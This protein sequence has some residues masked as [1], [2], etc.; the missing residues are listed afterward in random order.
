[1]DWVQL[2]GVLGGGAASGVLL[3]QLQ[4]FCRYAMKHRTLTRVIDRADSTPEQWQAAADALATID[5]PLPVPRPAHRASLLAPP[6]RPSPPSAP[7]EPAGISVGPAPGPDLPC[8]ACLVGDP[9]PL[10]S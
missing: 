7:A 3:G 9:S 10:R 4:A 2:I 1:M 5:G 6:T 8:P